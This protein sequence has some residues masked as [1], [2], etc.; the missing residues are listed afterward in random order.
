MLNFRICF[1]IWNSF[2]LINQ[3][4][5]ANTNVRCENLGQILSSVTMNWLD[6]HFDSHLVRG[7]SIIPNERNTQDLASAWQH[8]IRQGGVYLSVG[9]ERGLIGAW[10]SGAEAILW[11]DRDPE[12]VAYNYFTRALIA[13]ARN[14]E[15]Y[16]YLRLQAPNEVIRSRTEDKLDSNSFNSEIILPLLSEKFQPWWDRVVRHSSGWQ[17][18]DRDFMMSRDFQKGNYLNDDLG[19]QYIQNIVLSGHSYI[20]NSDLANINLI[21]H[22]L[23]DIYEKEKLSLRILDISNAWE[24]GYLGHNKTVQLIANLSQQTFAYGNFNIVLSY[25]K[26][27]P[28]V[29][30]GTSTPWTFLLKPV[31]FNSSFNSVDWSDTLRLAAQSVAG[32]TIGFGNQPKHSR[33]NDD[34]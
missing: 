33:F 9:T 18:F 31:A 16:L 13:V 25:M 1:L 29:H 7:S 6:Q 22:S 12:V 4:A 11:V 8:Q 15:D 14:R 34:F 27:S 10:L 20:L 30:E 21:S 24:E 32:P 2:F 28:I 3:I 26:A 17:G 23:K 5:K 19:F